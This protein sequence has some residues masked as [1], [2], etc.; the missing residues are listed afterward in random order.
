MQLPAC[1]TSLCCFFFGFWVS[2]SLFLCFQ[3]IF[4]YGLLHSFYLVRERKDVSIN[5]VDI[6]CR[7]WLFFVFL[8]W[9]SESD[10]QAKFMGKGE[11]SHNE[12]LLQYCS[13]HLVLKNKIISIWNALKFQEW[14]EVFHQIL[15]KIFILLISLNYICR[16]FFHPL[17]SRYL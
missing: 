11:R 12:P 15:N 2:L 1:W 4:L 3:N 14:L 5:W 16:S 17:T 9:S 7:L 8:L 13:S 10:C 6:L